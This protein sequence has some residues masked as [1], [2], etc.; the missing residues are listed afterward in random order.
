MCIDDRVDICSLVLRTILTISGNF[1]P[2]AKFQSSVTLRRIAARY[3]H[4]IA[5]AGHNAR[6]SC[7]TEYSANGASAG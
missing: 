5:A 7:R 3:G 2:P 1:R 6:P 4:S